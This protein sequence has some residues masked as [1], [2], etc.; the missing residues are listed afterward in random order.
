MLERIQALE[1]HVTAA[2]VA[3]PPKSPFDT[4]VNTQPDQFEGQHQQMVT[5]VVPVLGVR[6]SARRVLDRVD[7]P[8]EWSNNT[9]WLLRTTSQIKREDAHWTT[10]SYS[11]LDIESVSCTTLRNV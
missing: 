3:A 9:M 11:S 7:V 1:T 8:G 10:F 2:A 4:K 5:L 6:G